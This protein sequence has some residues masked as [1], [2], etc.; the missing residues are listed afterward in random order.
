M[1]HWR[2]CLRPIAA[3]LAATFRHA[4][5]N[6]VAKLRIRATGRS[7][8]VPLPKP[9]TATPRKPL[10]PRPYAS[11]A[12]RAPRP[13]ALAA[14]P[15]ACASCGA[16]VLKRRRRYCDECLPKARRDRGL[17]AIAAARKALAAQAAAGNDPR[18]SVKAGRKRGE[19][20]SEQ[21]RRNRSWARGA[22]A[23]RD[24][25]WFARDRP[26]ARRLLAEPNRRGYRLI[27][28]GL[29]ADPIWNSC[30]ASATL[31]GAH[32]A[33]RRRGTPLN[34]KR[35][36]Y[37]DPARLGPAGFGASAARRQAPP[38]ANAL[39]RARRCSQSRSL[40]PESPGQVTER[41]CT[42]FDAYGKTSG[43]PMGVSIVLSPTTRGYTSNEF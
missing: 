33:A 42:N 2:E 15:I 37:G 24:A 13:E 21:H 9:L 36:G 29:L 38:I 20:I 3:G 34:T 19:A 8:A 23:D 14:N 41:G 26:E 32:A 10:P 18:A 28:R 5:L 31:G 25:R 17:R 11:K 22:A 43:M 12:S 39:R 30:A 4:L 27:A 40:D 16:P 6:K 1:P 35:G 7:R